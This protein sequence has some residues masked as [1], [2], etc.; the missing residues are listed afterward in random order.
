MGIILYAHGG[1]RNH[2]CEAI[3]RSTIG[4]LGNNV[5]TYTTDIKGDLRY[6]LDSITTLR[7]MHTTKESFTARLYSGLSRRIF[8]NYAPLIKFQYKDLLGYSDQIMVSVGG[9]NYCNGHPYSYMEANKLLSKQNK[10]VLWGCSVTPELLNDPTLIED[11]NRYSMIVARESLTFN[12]LKEKKITSDVYLFP[13][14]AFSLQPV[15]VELPKK[16]QEGNTIGINLSPLVEAASGGDNLVLSGIKMVI[17]HILQNTDYQIALIP[18]VVWKKSDDLVSL[19][20]L[21]N[22]YRDSDRIII[23]DASKK[24]GCREIKYI[25]SKCKI[26]IAARTHASIAAYSSCVPTMVLGYSVKS[27]GIAMDL[28]GTDLHYVVPVQGL[29]KKEKV[30]NDYI[31]I[32]QHYEEIKNYLQTVMPDYIEKSRSAGKLL[33]DMTRSL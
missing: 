1:S 12:A 3:V 21:Y 17:Q 32:E 28:F 14:P 5:L 11:M 31:W 23:V 33:I 7:Q 2:G 4:M 9:D 26:M 20:N 25:I 19:N 29:D 30:L 18:H 10:T 24:L 16:F 22:K 27:K 8:N 15:P 6:G 13:D